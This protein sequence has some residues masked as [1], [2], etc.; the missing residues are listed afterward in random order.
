MLKINSKEIYTLKNIFLTLTIT[1][2]MED[3]NILKMI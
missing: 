3:K 1:L 2:I